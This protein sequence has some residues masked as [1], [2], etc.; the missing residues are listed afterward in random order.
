ME[1]SLETETSYLPQRLREPV[2]QG[3]LTPT[4]HDP[5]EQAF[6]A[7]QKAQDVVPVQLFATATEREMSVLAIAA[8]PRAPLTEYHCRELA[9]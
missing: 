9:R 2:V 1:A 5:I 4:E 3:R 7:F 8:T 6:A